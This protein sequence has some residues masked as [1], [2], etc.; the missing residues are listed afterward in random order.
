MC[1]NHNHTV[2]AKPA[3]AKATPELGRRKIIQGAVAG[4]ALMASPAL[5]SCATNAETGRKQFVGLAPGAGQLN[6]MA[7]A[8]W[9]EMK[10]KTPTSTDPR[11][12]NRLRNIGGRIAKGANRS[13]QK[14]DYAVF[15]TDTKNAFVLPGNR[16]GFY[17]G[18][19]DFTDNDDQIAGIMGHEVGHVSGQH[20]RERYSMQMASQ[21]AVAGG[22]VIGASQ[23]SKKCNRYTGAARNNCLQSANRNTQYLAQA[24]GLGAMIGLVLP[25]SRKHEAESDLLGANYMQRAGYNPYE[26]VKLWEKMAANNPSRQP[27]FL[28]THPDPAWRARN[29]DEY[30][31]R[32]EKLGSQG[33]KNIRT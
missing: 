26:A 2:E 7:A 27:Q 33:F 31:R 20:A 18:M 1:F 17:K 23:M 11:Y 13:N 24:L 29:L 10:Q 19:M 16:V 14:W 15:D 25:Y 8:S 3:T 6:S 9:A 4:G 28:S 22:T 5:V 30:I 21:V 32:Q 12:T